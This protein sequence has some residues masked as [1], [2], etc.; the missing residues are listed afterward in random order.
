[1]VRKLPLARGSG[2]IYLQ[3]EGSG[4]QTPANL[5]KIPGTAGVCL[6]W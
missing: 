5:N 1:M 2:G 3:E 6:P 4:P